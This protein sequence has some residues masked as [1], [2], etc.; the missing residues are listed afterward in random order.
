GTIDKLEAIP[1]YKTDLARE[2]FLDNVNKCGISVVG[3]SGNLT[4]VSTTEAFSQE[5]SITA[6]ANSDARLK[7]LLINYRY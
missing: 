2:V 5:N 3:Q 1:G 6:T 4:P 7:I